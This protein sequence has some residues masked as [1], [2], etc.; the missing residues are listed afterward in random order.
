MYLHTSQATHVPD[1]PA[2]TTVARLLPDS[3]LSR[4]IHHSS[5]L[6]SPLNYSNSFLTS[7]PGE[8][9]CLC[10]PRPDQCPD[11][12]Q[13]VSRTAL[14]RSTNTAYIPLCSIFYRSRS[15]KRWMTNG[16]CF[17][18]R[19][20][21]HSL[22]RA[23]RCVKLGVSEV[24][25]PGAYFAVLPSGVE[26]GSLDGLFSFFKGSFLDTHYRGLVWNPWNPISPTSPISPISPISMLP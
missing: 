13:D 12:T 18:H 4:D 22:H 25:R 17:L 24:R 23:S 16:L 26:L 3:G 5:T 10:A 15:L 21:F 8:P 7:D 9:I 2:A 11:F 20:L 6:S 19:T 1:C 14:R